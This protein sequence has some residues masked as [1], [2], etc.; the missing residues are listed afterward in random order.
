MKK[1]AILFCLAWGI[2]TMVYAQK[3]KIYE[4]D[5]LFK[6]PDFIGQPVLLRL[7]NPPIVLP[8]GKLIVTTNERFDYI[9]GKSASGNTFRLNHDGTYDETFKAFFMKPIGNIPASKVFSGGRVAIIPRNSFSPS[10]QIFIFTNNGI[11]TLHTV[12]IP[13]FVND[14]VIQSDGKI[15]LFNWATG[16]SRLRSDG[17][18]DSTFQFRKATGDRY[19]TFFFE[20]YL[21]LDSNDKIRMVF[22]Q[23]NTLQIR[24]Y[25]KEGQ[26]ESAFT[27]RKQDGSVFST[28]NTLIT[29]VSFFP[30]GKIFVKDR[31]T[32]TYSIF[33]DAGTWEK[34]ST[35]PTG[36]ANEYADNILT[37]DGNFI[38]L[39]SKMPYKIIAA[40]NEAKPLLK[41]STLA[42]VYG[43]YDFTP[44]DNGKF[45]LSNYATDFIWVD[46]SGHVLQKSNVRL[47][48]SKVNGIR[49]L[50]KNDQ[51]LVDIQ[52]DF[53]ADLYRLNKDGRIDSTIAYPSK[54][55]TLPSIY[56]QGFFDT[57]QRY[58]GSSNIAFA[59]AKNKD[60]YALN[61]GS[62]IL[63][64]ET[65]RNGI[66]EYFSNTYRIRAD[67]SI[68]NRFLRDSA[69]T[70]PLPNDFFLVTQWTI[71]P[72][73]N[74]ARFILNNEGQKVSPQ[75]TFQQFV[76][77]QS[78]I[79]YWL[80]NNG[81]I[82][83]L[84][85]LDNKHIFSRLLADGTHDLSFSPVTLT[86]LD[87]TSGLKAIQNDNK[88]LIADNY[89]SF[90][91]YNSNGIPDSTFKSVV[92]PPD[93]FYGF[94]P[95]VY[96]QTD[97]KILIFGGF[98][99]DGHVEFLRLNAD[100]SL[101]TTFILSKE[102]DPELI[103]SIYP[104][105]DQEI[106]LV[107][108]GRIERLM[109]H[110]S[111]LQPQINASK[112]QACAN[113]SVKL[114]IEPVQ[115][116]SYQWHKDN[117]E[118]MSAGSNVSVS[119]SVAG[120]YKV[121]AKDANCGT[122]T[123]DEVKVSFSPLPEARI[124]KI[125]PLVGSNPAAGVF[126]VILEANTGTNLSYQWQ[127]DN[128]D[129]KEATGIGYEAK[130][131][132]NYAVKVSSEGCSNRSEALF[133]NIT[134]TVVLGIDGQERKN[135]ISVSPNPNKGLFR[136]DLP[137]E[138]KGGKVELFDIMGRVLPIH[139]NADEFQATHL[140]KG[141]YVLRVSKGLKTM[142]TKVVIE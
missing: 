93:R 56:T 95:N 54:K 97:Q 3:K 37:A 75:N 42:P 140:N 101:D 117:K 124:A 104:V 121:V 52:N 84:E 57:L 127:K 133:I 67:G 115:G 51:I 26:S 71:H 74:N 77:K 114:S 63:N 5:P 30:D 65:E 60:V 109:L 129:I 6:S 28:V 112:T 41:D 58:G 119:T 44:L 87:Q 70:I 47:A 120:S 80:L 13:H 96:A 128:E 10:L 40:T 111:S 19:Q 138:L 18:P 55:P 32:N 125:T 31:R 39:N 88:L 79:A 142:T 106:L 68:D 83:V 16:L 110:C 33:S 82:L 134:P 45:L 99:E 14:A 72:N 123:S 49:A 35:F 139:Q 46:S 137:L 118:L 4:L 20:K 2:V 103:S 130:D 141:T 7:S 76:L 27:L 15:I 48:Q 126:S 22:S 131:S 61:D 107:Y 21:N 53:N 36:E 108:K 8:D 90:R 85:T 81:K 91:R 94:S 17:T 25:S 92:P 1:S 59:Y 136:L 100:G 34:S 64:R 102:I 11:D 38:E 105:S 23:D 9:N 50:L 113:E 29:Q 69:V 12:P 89:R 62:F 122:L 116:F 73:T 66:F 86:N 43:R 78:F 132:G 135:G 24:L 98:G